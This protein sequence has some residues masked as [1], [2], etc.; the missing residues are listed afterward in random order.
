MSN[1]RNDG[2]THDD[3]TVMCKTCVVPSRL[4]HTKQHH[5]PVLALPLCLVNHHRQRGSDLVPGS[6][7]PFRDTGTTNGAYLTK[8]PGRTL[9]LLRSSYATAFWY[10]L[11]QSKEYLG[12]AGKN[13][14]GHE[15]DAPRLKQ[16]DQRVSR[17]FLSRAAYCSAVLVHY[18]GT[19]GERRRGVSTSL[20]RTLF[21]IIDF[22]PL[23]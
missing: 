15:E 9:A 8:L 22:G 10:G 23:R 13:R 2:G 12:V 1:N 7:R 6:A 21:S 5:V 3:C 19:L 4:G 17:S 18:V 11:E 20:C 14:N 16:A